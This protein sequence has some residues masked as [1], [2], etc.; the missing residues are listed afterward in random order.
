[1]ALR[2]QEYLWFEKDKGLFLVLPSQVLLN[3]ALEAYC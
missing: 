3:L 1:M 2:A